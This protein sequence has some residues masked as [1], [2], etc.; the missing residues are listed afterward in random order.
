MSNPY[1]DKTQHDS[2]YHPYMQNSIVPPPPP[3]WALKP[4]KRKHSW[5]LLSVLIVFVACLAVL[6]LTL[7]IRPALP[8]SPS[9]KSIQPTPIMNNYTATDILTDFRKEGC[10]CGNQMEND[11]SI[12]AFSPWITTV[13]VQSVSSVVWT[14]PLQEQLGLW[15]YDTSINAQLAYAQVGQNEKYPQDQIPTLNPPNDYLHGRCLLLVTGD[16]HPAQWNGYPISIRDATQW[17]GYY[18]Q[19]MDTYCT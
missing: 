14:D 19:T 8:H 15:V 18:I 4:G 7:W 10:M 11:V 9:S 6:L 13:H 3:E 16:N 17:N 1:D 5:M 2:Y 12:N